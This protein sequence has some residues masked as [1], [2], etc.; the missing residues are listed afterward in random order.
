[1]IPLGQV[2]LSYSDNVQMKSWL[3]NVMAGNVTIKSSQLG[4]GMYHWTYILSTSSNGCLLDLSSMC[5][6]WYHCGRFGTE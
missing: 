3:I 4:S 5:K 2:D 6:E 1:M